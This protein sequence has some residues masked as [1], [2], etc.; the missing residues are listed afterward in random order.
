MITID[1]K[2][3]YALAV[4]GGV[5]S[6][7][8]LHIFANFVHHI[9][10][11]V[12]TIN[13]GLRNQAA[14]DCRFVADYCAKL[15]VRCDIYNVDVPTY[16]AQHKLSDETAARLL[17]YKVLDE[18]DCDRVC[19]AHNADDNAETVLMHI[20]RGSGA[21]GAT[22]IRRS[23]G[24][25]HR[26][27]LDMSRAEI[28][29]YAHVNNVPYVTD[30]TNAD[31]KYTRNFVRHKVLPLLSEINPAVKSNLVRFADNLACDND[32]L[33]SLAD[34]SAVQFGADEA[35]I[36]KILLRQPRAITY[37]V[38][39]KVFARLG[40]HYDIEQTH[41]DAIAAMTDGAGGKR[42]YLPFGWTCYDD[43]SCL[44]LT[45]AAQERSVSADFEASFGLGKMPVPQGTLCVTRQYAPDALR[46]DL[47]KVPAGA[48]VRTMRAGD[49]FTKF[50][51]GTKPLRRYLTDRKIPARMRSELLVVCDGSD[52]LVIVGVEISDRVKTDPNSDTAYIYLDK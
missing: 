51:G 26:P 18:L 8:M 33:C 15:G 7:V 36:P 30:S 11:F 45:K 6:M 13:H 14:D 37:R 47:N 23:N 32:Y 5:D 4:S 41:F 1:P 29:R 24:K 16:A 22:G 17:R 40:V 31:V 48:V 12:A 20:I 27:L 46:L 44:T 39:H 9:D 3:K 35:R 52:V 43:Y 2:L 19:L 21:N 42:I 38:L 50:G 49:M 34:I 10:F 25:Y 28:E